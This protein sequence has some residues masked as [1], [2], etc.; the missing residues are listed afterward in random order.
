M[1]GEQARFVGTIPETYERVLGPFLFDFYAGD[2]A[3]R[4]EAPAGGRVLEIACGTGISTEAAR[5]A[6]DRSVRITA[7]DLNPPMLELARAKRGHLPGVDF[8]EADAQEL[9][10]PDATF[11]ALFCQF[12]LMFLPDKAQGFREALRVLKP[13]GL[14]AFNVWDS[15]ERNPIA[16]LAHQTIGEFFTADPPQFL[17]VPFGWYAHDIIHAHVEDAG[18]ANISIEAL[19]YDASHPNAADLAYG[20]VHGNPSILE[21]EERGSAAPHEVVATLTGRLI[22]AYGNEPLRTRVQAIVVTA[23]RPD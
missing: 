15:L 11:D 10:Y 16:A 13:G 4:L 12:G 9:P 22:E 14:L 21:I 23:R 18:F 5:A 19:P 3:A 6:L 1:S 8:S 20:W 2:L 17:T 7:T